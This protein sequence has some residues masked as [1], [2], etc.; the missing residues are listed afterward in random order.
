MHKLHKEVVALA[1]GEYVPIAQRV[2]QYRAKASAD[3][4][5]TIVELLKGDF[6]GSTTE[7]LHHQLRKRGLTTTVSK[8]REILTKLTKAHRVVGQTGK[9]YAGGFEKN[10]TSKVGERWSWVRSHFNR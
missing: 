4:E 3:P 7:Q 6:S 8:V 10:D 2:K 9:K 5:P 1:E